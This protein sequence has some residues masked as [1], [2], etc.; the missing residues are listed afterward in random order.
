[1]GVEPDLALV[2]DRL[3]FRVQELD[4]ILDGEDVRAGVL[5]TVI[6]HRSERRRLARAA[7]ADH[8]YEPAP[9]H[10]EVLE[11]G[12]HAELLEGRQLRGDEAQD[13]RDVAA[14]LEDICAEP[15]E[16]GLGEG[17]IDLEVAREPL[18]LLLVHELQSGLTHHLRRQLELIDGHDL[19]FDL[20]HDR[21]MRGEEEVR[22]L[23]VHHELEQRLD[24]HP[25]FAAFLRERVRP[26]DA[27]RYR[28]IRAGCILNRGRPPCAAQP[29]IPSLEFSSSNSR[30]ESPWVLPACS[31][32]LSSLIFSLSSFFESALR[33][34]SSY[35]IAPSSYSRYRA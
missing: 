22:G 12:G 4:G 16:A 8:Q 21:R 17:E 6:D 13:H 18:Q 7:R 10:D 19:A 5:V 9:Q 29:I 20:D 25:G 30:L 3:V 15:A 23:L 26:F 2:D 14:L 11:I 28:C 34:A 35:E 33:M 24:V 1:M 27:E 32:L 31:R